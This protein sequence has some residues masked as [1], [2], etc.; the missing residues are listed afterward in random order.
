V[1]DAQLLNPTIAVTARVL[2][3]S[4]DRAAANSLADELRDAWQ[5][6]PVRQPEECSAGSWVFRDL[7][8]GAELGAALERVGPPTAWHDVAAKIVAGDLVGAAGVF[9]EIGAVPDEAYAR[10][11]AAEELARAGRRV[12][13]DAQLRLALPVFAQLGATAWQSEAESLLAASA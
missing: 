6:V 5:L 1:K 3:A 4:G 11:R 9:A 13:A 12:D 7:S 10:L 2:L 8:R